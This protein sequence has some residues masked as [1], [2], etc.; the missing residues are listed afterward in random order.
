[1]VH[2]KP[3]ISELEEL[4]AEIVETTNDAAETRMAVKFTG[5]PTKLL[6]LTDHDYLVIDALQSANE[7]TMIMLEPL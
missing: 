1:M 7:P 6:Q 3:Y 2:L 5:T 4:G